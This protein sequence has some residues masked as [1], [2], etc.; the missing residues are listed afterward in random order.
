MQSRTDYC[1]GFFYAQTNQRE[2]HKGQGSLQSGQ[3]LQGQHSREVEGRC[4][5]AKM[6]PQARIEAGGFTY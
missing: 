6:N 2:L 4:K 5:V 1:A 3:D